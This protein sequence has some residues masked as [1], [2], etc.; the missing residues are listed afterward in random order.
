MR[1]V[2]P[3]EIA[4]GRARGIEVPAGSLVDDQGNVWPPANTAPVNLPDSGGAVGFV[5]RQVARA[6]I[7]TA[8]GAVLAGAGSGAAAGLGAGPWGALAG[9]LIGGVGG[10]L[11]T[12]A[13]Q[14]KALRSIAESHPTGDIARFVR[15][16]DIDIAEHPRWAAA[17]QLPAAVFG[18]GSA[19]PS[20]TSAIR[21]PRTA[22]VLGGMM[23]SMD[24]GTQL[25]TTGRVDPV[26]S[27]IM[28]GG[29]P[30]F[31]GKAGIP[32]IERPADIPTF[33]RA[34]RSTAIPD[35]AARL[36][37]LQGRAP[38]TVPVKSPVDIKAIMEL[39]PEG[40]R[41]VA[42]SGKTAD[43]RYRVL[44]SLKE[45]VPLTEA[46]YTAILEG[47]PAL[48]ERKGREILIRELPSKEAAERRQAEIEARYQQGLAKA[49]EA[50]LVKQV[51][52]VEERITSVVDE[53]GKP[54]VKQPPST[55]QAE[56]SARAMIAGEVPDIKKSLGE[57]KAQLKIF[58]ELEARAQ[59]Y[60]EGS[61][62]RI[63]ATRTLNQMR[64]EIDAAER[65][66][67][68][69]RAG[70]EEPRAGVGLEEIRAPR[71]LEAIK[72]N[73]APTKPPVEPA[74]VKPVPPPEV[75]PVAKPP[76]TPP[77]E[78]VAPPTVKAP[79]TPE[80]TKPVQ[81][82][83]SLAELEERLRANEA[84]RNVARM[85]PPP[86]PPPPLEE[87]AAIAAEL[88]EELGDVPFETSAIKVPRAKAAKPKVAPKPAE[89]RTPY[90]TPKQPTE[91]VVTPP[92]DVET[93]LL[94]SDESGEGRR[95]RILVISHPTLRA[96]LKKGVTASELAE[97]YKK[98]PAAD[99]AELDRLFKIGAE[100]WPKGSMTSMA[101]K[102]IKKGQPAKVE[103]PAEG[104]SPKIVPPNKGQSRQSGAVLQ[105]LTPEMVAEFGAL[106][107]RPFTALKALAQKGR[108]PAYKTDL[109]AVEAVIAGKRPLSYTERGEITEAQAKARAKEAGLMSA[110]VDRYTYFF[111]PENQQDAIRRIK[112][113]Q[114]ARETPAWEYLH[115]KLLGYSDEDVAR[116]MVGH[117][118]KTFGA[119]VLRSA[120]EFYNVK[121]RE[122]ESRGFGL[123]MDI[124]KKVNPIEL[125]R[126]VTRPEATKVKTE[127]G[128]RY[129]KSHNTMEIQQRQLSEP[130]YA[131]LNK[132]G[133]ALTEAERVE[134]GNY[135][136]DFA[137]T[138]Q[139][140]IKL[141]PE[142]QKAADTMK[143]LIIE[144]GIEKRDKGPW[145]RAYENGR[146]IERPAE[147]LPNHFP[148]VKSAEVMEI[149][150]NPDKDP[151]LAAK[152]E[153]D[154]I[155]YVMQKGGVDEAAARDL[156]NL[157]KQVVVGPTAPNPMFRAM[158]YEEGLGLPRSWQ[159]PDP[160][161]AM[162][163]YI[164]RHATDLAYHLNI[165]S[166]PVLAKALNLDDM[167]KGNA[168]PDE[169]LTEGG[170]PVVKGELEGIKSI[171]NSLA[172]YVGFLDRTAQ[173]FERWQG[174]VHAGL[175]GPVSQSRNIGQ[176]IGMLP[177]ILHASEYRYVTEGIRKMFSPEATAAAVRAG[178]ARAG[179]N[180]LPAVAGDLADGVTKLA[181]VVSKYSGSEQLAR[182]NDVMLDVIGRAVAENRI[183]QGDKAFLEKFGP[184]DWKTKN[185]DE[186]VDHIAAAF[187][188]HFSGSYSAM[189]QPGFLLKGTQAQF[190]PLFKLARWSVGRFNRWYEHAYQPALEG[191]IKPLVTSL[192]GGML[193]TGVIN[194]LVE[195]LTERKPRELTWKEWLKLGGDK[196]TAYTFFSKAATAS[197]G[198]IMA[199]LAFGGVQLAHGE[200]PRSYDN[201]LFQ[202]VR[203]VLTRVGQFGNAIANGDASI[204]DLATLGFE[205]LKDQL[206]VLRV[207]DPKKDLGEREERIAARLGFVPRK[208]GL[209]GTLSDP[210]SAASAY[211]REDVGRLGR[212]MEGKRV[213]G[214]PL[215]APTDTI[216]RPG[217][218]EFIGAAQGGRARDEAYQRDVDETIKRRRLYSSALS[219]R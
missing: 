99:K 150:A 93:A 17:A 34:A 55:G 45:A 94:R 59:N 103:K 170:R 212:I 166:D 25:M 156:Y 95:A 68:E 44:A 157:Q 113:L 115:G 109:E 132:V 180:I 80:P 23:G 51:P 176:N 20:I 30:F 47:T 174:L 96:R 76:V 186:L 126:S 70:A 148:A 139:S 21:N 206:Q 165:E 28:A 219:S 100:S 39:S 1:E 16:T 153:K 200:L 135:L 92:R 167:G 213:R 163:R 201:L 133:K 78:P 211:K 168:V 9:G 120:R 216:R 33:N 159:E 118:M 49:G 189:D 188:R 29:G 208:G 217:Y 129:A 161:V 105:P 149:L 199:D 146:P 8:V 152:L 27:L 63:V 69:R 202:A 35:P 26:Q 215:R 155:D 72:E 214:E 81:R 102:L 110:E 97:A 122:T 181:D 184:K 89:E 84:A 218:Y 183:L 48:A 7:P 144:T 204:E 140:N 107:R 104:S 87:R 2:T 185:L 119:G 117:P 143:A 13:L 191:N 128:R 43:A 160:F 22:A 90:V 136:K 77:V 60:P 203:D 178:S 171:R 196:D 71:A 82:T 57:Y 56:A 83:P 194:K 195:E 65:A 111:K 172:D 67:F 86:P 11:G 4:L 198:G 127:A 106:L 175:I 31:A 52:Q 41:K 137:E 101:E 187:T 73:E 169:V 193:A 12:S 177:E 141:T 112:L 88:A 138:G 14:D 6:A 19:L 151:T 10:A 124:L 209:S 3:E 179:R 18:G 134:V 74:P 38:E 158:R 85:R 66:L 116:Y 15:Q 114:R 173:G 108:F 36:A 98:L 121:S 58:N 5:G 197:Y 42:G 61:P 37:E 125:L 142:Q 24:V 154:Y 64:N 147:L 62:E 145:V 130:R 75:A 50:G 53:G 192:A 123:P 207:L 131:E 210:L 40:L 182:A 164:N 91:P 190:A 162:R 205:S 79:E 46:D 32:A 54:V